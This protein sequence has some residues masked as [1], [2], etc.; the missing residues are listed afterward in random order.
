[1]GSLDDIMFSALSLDRTSFVEMFLDNGVSVKEF[2]TTKRL[3]QLYN[4]VS[5]EI[6]DLDNFWKQI[7]EIS[8]MFRLQ[9]LPYTYNLADYM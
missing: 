5:P 7:D 8:A 6:Y 4:A 2:L 9:V 1:M 3:L